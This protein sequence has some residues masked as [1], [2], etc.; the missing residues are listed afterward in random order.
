MPFG[1]PEE[2]TLHNKS[3]HSFTLLIRGKKSEKLFF[4]PSFS[5]NPHPILT[6]YGQLWQTL[7]LTHQIPNLLN[8]PHHIPLGNLWNSSPPKLSVTGVYPIDTWIF[9]ILKYKITLFYP[10]NLCHT[11]HFPILT[12]LIKSDNP[13]DIPH[14]SFPQSASSSCR[15]LSSQSP[16]ADKPLLP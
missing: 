11:T 9:D 16:S 7:F 1:K 2:S 8:N 5:L 6:H 14:R 10:L 4:H 13:I 12:Y 15:M 3:L